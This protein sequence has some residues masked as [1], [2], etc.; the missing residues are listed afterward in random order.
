MTISDIFITDDSFQCFA[1]ASL[2]D[3]IVAGAP[4]GR[5]GT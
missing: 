3:D 4:V 2:I 1:R 5:G